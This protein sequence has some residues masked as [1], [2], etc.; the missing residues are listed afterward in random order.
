MARPNPFPVP[1][2]QREPFQQPE[3]DARIFL[4]PLAPP[5]ILGLY[6]FAG[7]TFMVAAHMAKRYGGPMTD[8]YL[9]PFCSL[10]GGV[11]QFSA[12]MWS[13]RGVTAS[14]PRCTACGVRSG[15]RLACCNLR[16]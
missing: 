11:A 9:A 6:G 10:F 5:S 2:A 7:A 12:G 8:L 15:S 3:G 4:Q 13:F 14:R 16:S 1:D